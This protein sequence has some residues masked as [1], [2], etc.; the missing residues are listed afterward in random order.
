[1]LLWQAG[2]GAVESIRRLGGQGQGGGKAEGEVE[3]QEQGGDEQDEERGRVWEQ[4]REAGPH[5]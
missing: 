1:M 3:G 4:R 5:L 2:G